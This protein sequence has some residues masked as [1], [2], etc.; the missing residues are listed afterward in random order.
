MATIEE[1]K[2]ELVPEYEQKYEALVL[3]SYQLYKL[4]ENEIEMQVVKKAAAL[5]M[6]IDHCK[7]SVK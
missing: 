5:K 2:M 3:I 4:G 1:M 7:G 6:M